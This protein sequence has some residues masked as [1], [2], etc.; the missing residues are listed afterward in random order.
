[1]SRSTSN[2]RV[3]ILTGRL[4]VV[5]S[6][7]SW[8]SQG[9]PSKLKGNLMSWIMLKK[10]LKNASGLLPVVALCMSQAP[11]M[12][13]GPEIYRCGPAGSQ[14]F[15]QIPCEENSEKVIVED[16][17]MFSE[18]AAS[19]A[20]PTGF[21]EPGEDAAGQ[22]ADAASKAQAFITQLEKQRNEQLAEIDQSIE[23]LQSRSENPEDTEGQ[24]G[25]GQAAAISIANLQNTRQ[26]IM[27]EY[28]AM[29][30]AAR[31]RIDQP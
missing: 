10:T 8:I 23:E 13:A 11:L 30:V 21:A 27:S 18:T 12:A 29:I 25:D 3:C 19:D 15:S 9:F 26:S 4:D 24:S 2:V 7:K 14:R 20:H 5:Q 6:G 1:M 16:Q 17:F 28:E 22:Q 31:Q